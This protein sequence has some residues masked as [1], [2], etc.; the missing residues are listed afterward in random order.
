MTK[1]THRRIAVRTAEPRDTLYYF[2]CPGCD[3]PHALNSTWSFNDNVY[4]PTFWP[5]VLS[6]G[7]GG[8]ICHSFVKEGYIQF[9]SDCTHSLN[10]QTVP[11][12]PVPADY[13]LTWLSE[14]DD[15]DSL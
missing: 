3:Q 7:P 10:D 11:L 15:Q 8:T 6:H 13:P 14:Q 9:L 1:G 2:H 4:S 5:S 12:P